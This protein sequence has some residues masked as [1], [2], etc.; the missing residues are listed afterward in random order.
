MELKSRKC[1]TSTPDLQKFNKRSRCKCNGFFVLR[2]SNMNYVLSLFFFVS[3]SVAFAQLDT[4]VVLFD[5]DSAELSAEQKESL[6]FLSGRDFVLVSVEAHCDT[7]GSVSYNDRLAQRRLNHVL[8]FLPGKDVRDRKVVGEKE[9][10]KASRYVADEFRRVEVRYIFEREVA[11]DHVIPEREEVVEIVEEVLPENKEVE[12][13][14]ASFEE[15]LEDETKSAEII[16]TSILFYNRSVQYLPVSEPEL[17]ALCV[18]LQD[19]PN[20]KAHIRGHICCNPYM[21]WDDISEGRAKTVYEYL[22]NCSIDKKR[23]TY[24][25]Y[26]TSEPFRSPERTA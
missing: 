13:I 21:E 9:A 3:T 22:R 15:F 8:D 2:L 5:F 20:V 14:T 1:C 12:K 26:G 4:L 17:E 16:Q 25:G 24:R 7:S 10:A 18:F 6:H 11:E 23:L 19:N